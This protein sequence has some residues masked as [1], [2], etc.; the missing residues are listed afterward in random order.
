M[1]SSTT[2]VII[3]IDIGSSS[4]RCSAYEFLG[5]ANDGNHSLVKPIP[6]C[7]SSRTVRSVQPNTGKI[8]LLGSSAGDKSLMDN[9]DICMDDLLDRLRQVYTG[10]ESSCGAFQVLAVGFSS[11]VMNLVGV[12]QEGNIVGDEASISYACNAPSVAKQ[13]RHLRRYENSSHTY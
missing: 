6:N 9:L 4:I 12:D 7:R 2:N 10:N 13:C 1:S 5:S 3:A 8:Q 11:F